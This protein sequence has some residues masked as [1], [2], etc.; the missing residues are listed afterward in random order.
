MNLRGADKTAFLPGRHVI[1]VTAATEPDS[2]RAIGIIEGF[3][4]VYI[5]DR[6][7]LAERNP[8]GA[9]PKP[10]AERTLP[11]HGARADY[12]AGT[13]PGALQARFHD[14]N[15]LFGTQ[16]ASDPCP[17]GATYQEAMGRGSPWDERD[18]HHRLHALQ[19]PLEEP[20]ECQSSSTQDASPIR[21]G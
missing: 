2:A 6:H 8:V 4:P 9:E 16:D 13:A 12:P 7:K 17:R 19:Q 18:D 3:S 1:T 20:R 5:E 10:T 14:N 15:H 11:V 21:P